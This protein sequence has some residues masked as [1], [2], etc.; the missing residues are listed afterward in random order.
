MFDVA[1]LTLED[2]GVIPLEHAAVGDSDS[3]D[4]DETVFTVGNPRGVRFV[5]LQ[6][7]RAIYRGSIPGFLFYYRPILMDLTCKPGS[8]GSAILNRRAEVVG[9]VTMIDDDS[10]PF[11]YGISINVVKKL[12]PKLIAGGEIKHGMIGILFVNAWELT[13]SQKR[14]YQLENI[15]GSDALMIGLVREGSPAQLAGIQKGDILL[16][17]SGS[18]DG[19]W[20]PIREAAEFM[21]YWNSTFFAGDEAFL[22][23][24]RGDTQFLKKVTL[25]PFDAVPQ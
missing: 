2:S 10:R 18:P 17:V 11:C 4:T 12:L 21:E 20:V 3:L 16:E 5:G 24:R 14:N 8:S 22:K 19:P 9:M 13:P 25:I 15:A 6:G 23:L 1:L 7:Q